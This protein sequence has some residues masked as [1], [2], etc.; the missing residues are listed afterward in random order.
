MCSKGSERE[1]EIA[2]FNNKIPLMLISEIQSDKALNKKE[3]NLFLV[4]CSV[5]REMKLHRID[6]CKTLYVNNRI[7]L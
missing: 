6:S 4:N 7:L 3:L 5:T 2:K 1:S